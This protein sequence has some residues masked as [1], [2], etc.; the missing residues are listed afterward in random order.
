MSIDIKLRKKNWQAVSRLLRAE[1]GVRGSDDI[2]K[3]K[4]AYFG[5]IS[6]EE[7]T[8]RPLVK[9]II[10]GEVT[11]ALCSEIRNNS[12]DL[13]SLRDKFFK[14]QESR[15]FY[16]GEN[17]FL[18]HQEVQ[19][20]DKLFEGA[21]EFE[22]RVKMFHGKNYDTL[23]DCLFLDYRWSA[24]LTRL[25]VPAHWQQWRCFDEWRACVLSA[26]D[27]AKPISDVDDGTGANER[28][29]LS[30]CAVA[31][32]AAHMEQL[33]HLSP[34]TLWLVESMHEVLTS[35]DTPE[36]IRNE[37]RRVT[38]LRMSDY[39]DQCPG[40][41]LTLCVRYET[42]EQLEA[43]IK[44]LDPKTRYP[45]SADDEEGRIHFLRESADWEYRLSSEMLHRLWDH[46]A[47]FS[48]YQV[49]DETTLVV[50]QRRSLSWIDVASSM[51][52]LCYNAVDLKKR[53]EARKTH[54]GD[55]NMADVDPFPN[56]IVHQSVNGHVLKVAPTWTVAHKVQDHQDF[57]HAL[58]EYQDP[59]DLALE[60][61]KK[62]YQAISENL[63]QSRNG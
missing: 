38:A 41:T 1:L 51:R 37:F 45:F 26:M 20:Y 35:P 18:G 42:V 14:M 27:S 46:G 60:L 5:E 32:A 47:V 50:K 13:V 6:L 7:A 55:S 49:I 43:A 3:L 24:M 21:V 17:S 59:E 11:D 10:A 34:R 31:W 56:A 8:K 53:C 25:S 16:F 44:L 19:I 29:M 39:E 48:G 54:K 28:L 23:E 57:V 4:A 40:G 61:T 15:K 58:G 62:K 9:L 33:Q 2:K 63:Y 52:A 12:H 22:E 30:L 36:V